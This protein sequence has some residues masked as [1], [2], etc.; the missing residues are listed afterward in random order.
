M[1]PLAD[2][3]PA[4]KVL[5]AIRDVT[6]TVDCIPLIASSIM[7]K[8]L[9][10]GIDAAAH[11]GASL[12]MSLQDAWRMYVVVTVAYVVAYAAVKQFL[13]DHL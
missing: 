13:V 6:A 7:S 12:T 2:L 4:D 10:E 5:Y 8:K 9:A 1:P 11:R 3:A